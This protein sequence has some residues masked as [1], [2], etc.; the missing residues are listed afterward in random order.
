M[1]A[2]SRFIAV[3][4]A[5]SGVS[6][7]A[8]I[9]VS[10]MVDTNFG[11]WFALT[12]L[13]TS[14]TAKVGYLAEG[15]VLDPSSTFAS[16]NAAWTNA[17]D[18]VFAT[19]DA[20]GQPGR[21]SGTVTYTDAQGFAGKDV[22]VWVTDGNS[23]YNVVLRSTTVD[24]LADSAEPNQNALSLSSTTVAQNELLLG[25]YKSDSANPGGT[26]TA[27][28]PEPTSVLLGALGFISFIARRRR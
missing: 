16:I 26:Y 21:F 3:L 18:I 1:K 28:L 27:V 22:Y 11:I 4:I 25:L 10:N 2:I 12:P 8:S 5:A 17:G 6:S 9:M 7:G 20:A 14:F 15:T 13:G 24:F 23:F 19:G